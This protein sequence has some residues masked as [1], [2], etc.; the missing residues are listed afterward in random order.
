[1]DFSRA[2]SSG[3]GSKGRLV[4]FRNALRE[5][6]P[7]KLDEIITAGRREG[8]ISR[9]EVG[10]RVDAIAGALEAQAIDLLRLHGDPVGGW[11]G[12][13]GRLAKD[14]SNLYV[15]LSGAFGMGSETD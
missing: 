1:M 14:V 11:D 3:S 12:Y 13:D 6:P 2:V 10:D 15:A 7:E 8:L 5:L 9:Q 4:R